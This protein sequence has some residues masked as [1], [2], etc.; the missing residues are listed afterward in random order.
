MAM[1]GRNIKCKQHPF[2]WQ[3]Q[4][5]AVFVVPGLIA[6]MTCH[7]DRFFLSAP[8]HSF[9]LLLTLQVSSSVTVLLARY[10]PTDPITRACV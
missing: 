8:R 1:N 3:G 5:K 10:V 4:G 7:P 2:Q 9:S 6:T